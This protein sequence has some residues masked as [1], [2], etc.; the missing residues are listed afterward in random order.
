[1]IMIFLAAIFGISKKMIFSQAMCLDN[2]WQAELTK[3]Y[4]YIFRFL[5]SAFTF[6]ACHQLDFEIWRDRECGN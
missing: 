2:D 1:M 6:I 3:Q 5:V 4:L